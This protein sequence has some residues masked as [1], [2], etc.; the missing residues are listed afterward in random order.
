M[1]ISQRFLLAAS[2]RLEGIGNSLALKTLVSLRGPE[3]E[4]HG[5][6]CIFERRKERKEASPTTFR[7]A[8][9]CLQCCLTLFGSRSS[10]GEAEGYY[11]THN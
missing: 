11:E 6:P 3:L 5:A 4:F 2:S 1:A 9:S 8:P 7:S 10:A